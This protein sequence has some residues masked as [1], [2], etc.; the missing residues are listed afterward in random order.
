MLVVLAV[1]V[2]GEHF[3]LQLL[4][5]VFKKKEAGYTACVIFNVSQE[6]S[7]DGAS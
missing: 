4:A 1:T 3:M 7:T 2:A 5:F 6:L